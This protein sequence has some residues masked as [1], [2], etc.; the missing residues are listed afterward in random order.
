MADEK[1]EFENIEAGEDAPEQT[2]SETPKEEQGSMV[3]AG[4][5]G[6]TY[7]WKT[8]PTGT[9]APP[10]VDMDGKTVTLKKADIILPPPSREWVKSK[11]GTSEYKYCSFIL[12][13]DFESQREFYS[14]TRVFKRDGEKYSHPTMTRDRNNQ[15]SKL[16]GLYADFKKKDIQEVS[17]H[18]F[19]NFLNSKP[20]VKIA[21]GEVINPTTNETI[22]K[23]FIGEFVN[24]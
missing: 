21:T 17:L 5:S 1:N 16:L 2:F 24:P 20:Q 7:D 6:E 4:A 10:R 18:E 19:M 8:A 9:K 22:K 15:C 11:A 3:S 13:Y 23:N 14:G 12:E